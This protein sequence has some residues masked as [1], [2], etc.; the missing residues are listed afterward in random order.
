[1]FPLRP[2]TEMLTIAPVSVWRRLL[3]LVRSTDWRAQ[4]LERDAVA[5]LERLLELNSTRIKNDFHARVVESRHRLEQEL[6]E[7][8][9]HLL[10]CA[11]R[12]LEDARQVRA[13][14]SAHVEARLASIRA[15]RARLEA[16]REGKEA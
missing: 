5:Y 2:Y 11:E 1:M 13:A 6:R 12:A 7:R 16:L 15:I 8:L 3:D 4:A 9:R 14:G 10:S